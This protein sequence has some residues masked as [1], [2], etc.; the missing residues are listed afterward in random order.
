MIFKPFIVTKRLI[1]CK[2]AQF[3]FG[4][5]I[6]ML[7]QCTIYSI[8]FQFLNVYVCFFVLCNIKIFSI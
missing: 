7:Y 2:S 4:T 8:F 3:I 1:Y 5:L 6:S